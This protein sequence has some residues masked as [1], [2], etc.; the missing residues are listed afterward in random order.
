MSVL[1]VGQVVG[2]GLSI[3][4][5]ALQGLAAQDSIQGR[6]EAL[7]FAATNLKVDARLAAI[8]E[9]RRNRRII[10]DQVASVGA[11][12]VELEGST[13]DVIASNAYELELE[14]IN[15]IRLAD[16]Q[17]EEL[18]TAADNSGDGG[19][20]SAMGFINGFAGAL[21]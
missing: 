13:L 9:R 19:L 2:A 18:R 14:V 8:T 17:A 7:R 12:G 21:G 4:G 5:G 6:K 20:A 3:A 1:A 15:S 16:R 11:S 10:G